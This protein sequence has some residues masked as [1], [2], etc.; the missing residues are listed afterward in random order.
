M[1]SIVGTKGQIVIEKGIRQ[2]LG[3][4]AGYVAE[5]GATLPTTGMAP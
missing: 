1:S 5:S 3:I 2:A 4:Q